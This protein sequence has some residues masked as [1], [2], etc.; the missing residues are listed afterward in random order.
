M[1]YHMK[2]STKQKGLK[3]SDCFINT[4]LVE[5]IKLSK[6]I[7]VDKFTV[8]SV[9][10]CFN[11]GEVFELHDEEGIARSS[12]AKLLRDCDG[13]ITFDMSCNLADNYKIDERMIHDHTGELEKLKE[14]INFTNGDSC[15]K[16]ETH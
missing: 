15:T 6:D 11:D 13:S 14:I 3:S 10:V 12:L 8:Y 9:I 5:A 2:S 1:L 7:I 16:H 4:K